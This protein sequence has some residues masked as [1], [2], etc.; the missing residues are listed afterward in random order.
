MEFL[1]PT[2]MRKILTNFAAW[3]VITI[4]AASIATANAELELEQVEGVLMSRTTQ[5]LADRG[6]HLGD[7]NWNNFRDAIHSAS[8]DISGLPQEEQP[9]KLEEASLNI[10]LFIDL[11]IQRAEGDPS[12]GKRLGEQTFDYATSSLCPLWP[13]C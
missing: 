2:A 13:F 9:A 5:Y 8:R 7:S 12:Y 3:T 11:M 10:R 1:R 6:F 4:F